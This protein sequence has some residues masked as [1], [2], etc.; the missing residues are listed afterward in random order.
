MVILVNLCALAIN[1]ED[2]EM[3]PLPSL[4][5]WETRLDCILTAINDQGKAMNEAAQAQKK[6]NVALIRQTE[7]MY[8]VLMI[9]S[10]FLM[11]Q[12]TVES[13]KKV[14]KGKKNGKS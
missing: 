8:N 5:P 10:F 3:P 7:L 13:L 6:F 9:I 14:M 12:S 1:I 11:P 4:N 2:Y